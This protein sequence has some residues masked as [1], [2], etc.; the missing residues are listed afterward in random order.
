MSGL[1]GHVQA[2]GGGHVWRGRKAGYC[3]RAAWTKFLVA[4]VRY[5]SP[6]FT[7]TDPSK[8]R[9]PTRAN[10]RPASTMTFRSSTDSLVSGD[11]PISYSTPVQDRDASLC[12]IG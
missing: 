9:K 6:A 8:E 2:C 3:A 11:N 5:Q 12:F 10:A 7:A 4:G 1:G